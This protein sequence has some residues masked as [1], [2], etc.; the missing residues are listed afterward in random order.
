V[1]ARLAMLDHLTATAVPFNKGHFFQIEREAAL[2]Q[3][4]NSG[5]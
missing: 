3:W 4:Y 1:A 2:L 5:R